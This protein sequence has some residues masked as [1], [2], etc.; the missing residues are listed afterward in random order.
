[1]AT[2]IHYMPVTDMDITS[3]SYVFQWVKDMDMPIYSGS[4]LGLDLMGDPALD[5]GMH[6]MTKLQTYGPVQPYV[7]I[8]WPSY[9]H[10]A[11]YSHEYAYY[12]LVSDIRATIDMDMPINIQL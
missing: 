6:I 11:Q 4:Y 2:P 12:D 3:T 5:M 7:C 10:M 1:M 8:L 9:R